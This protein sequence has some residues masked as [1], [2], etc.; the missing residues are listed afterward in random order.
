MPFSM[1]C[2]LTHE[3]WCYCKYCIYR[4]SDCVAGKH[5]LFE[6]DK[7]L[8][9]Y[10]KESKEQWNKWQQEKFTIGTTGDSAAKEA[11]TGLWAQKKAPSGPRRKKSK[12]NPFKDAY[13]LHQARED[14]KGDFAQQRLEQGRKQLAVMDRIGKSIAVASMEDNDYYAIFLEYLRMDFQPETRRRGI[15]KIARKHKE[16]CILLQRAFEHNPDR[17]SALMKNQRILDMVEEWKQD[18]RYEYRERD[19]TSSSN[20]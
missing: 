7:E 6:N 20:W 12:E 1:H 2:T 10:C 18:D 11:A 4:F 8:E 17:Y 9:K 15:L 13:E 3:M 14:A 5:R 19:R 16:D